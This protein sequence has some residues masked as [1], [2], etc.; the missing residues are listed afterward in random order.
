MSPIPSIAIIGAGPGGL[1]LARLLHIN[2]LPCTIFEGDASS[3]SRSQGGTLDVHQE[4]GQAALKAAGLFGRF[5]ELMRLEGEAFRLAD[6]SGHLHINTTNIEAEG[7]RPEIDRIQLRQILLDSV[8]AENIRWDCKVKS[9]EG[10]GADGHWEIAFSDSTKP[11]EFFDLVVGADGAWSKVRAVLSDVRPF[12]SGVSGV[13]L[14]FGDVDINQPKISQLV[15]RGSYFA[16]SDNKGLLGQR[17]GDGSIRCYV[18]MRTPEDWLTDCGIN[19]SD[20]AETKTEIVK[21]YFDDWDEGLKDLVRLADDDSIITRKL[22]M[23]PVGFQWEPKQGITL[24]GD[25]AHLM[26]P[27]AG[28]GV[29]LAMHDTLDL[30]TAILARKDGWDA[31]ALSVDREGLDA[32]LRS[33]EIE[34]LKRAERNAVET[35]ENLGLCFRDDAPAGFMERMLSYGAP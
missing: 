7:N 9:I 31:K 22:F 3:N 19:F 5:Q 11:S 17:N 28:V 6:K 34:M 2:N 33:Y 27:F 29:N 13:D 4:S 26:T 14:R 10:P 35:W 30:A 21:R 16:F 18:M 20:P 8:P 32:A 1:T 24:L 12:Y 25:A 23:L 15:G